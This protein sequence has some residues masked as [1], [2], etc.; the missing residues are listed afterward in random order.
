M[1]L[2]GFLAVLALAMC[3]AGISFG[4]A[5][6]PPSEDSVFPTNQ[7]SEYDLD[8]V[9][10]TFEKSLEASKLK[11]EKAKVYVWYSNHVGMRCK[12]RSWSSWR[13]HVALRP[14]DCDNTRWSDH[15]IKSFRWNFYPPPHHYKD[16]ELEKW[17]DC[18]LTVWSE[19]DCKG[20]VLKRLD[21]INHKE[22]Y[23]NQRICNRVRDSDKPGRSV[24]LMCKPFS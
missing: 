16:G 11:K 17:G 13:H 24:S 3:F 9:D 19:K 14:N 18:Y 22:M 15:R 21:K 2:R 8:T 5:M 20:D 10:Q 4:A 1:H 23:R 7:T 12:K 6:N